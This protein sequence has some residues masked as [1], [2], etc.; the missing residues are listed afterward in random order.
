MGFKAFKDLPQPSKKRAKI[1]L[2][3]HRFGDLMSG[4][5]QQLVEQGGIFPS[6]KR[7]REVSLETASSIE[8]GEERTPFIRGPGGQDHFRTRMKRDF[9]VKFLL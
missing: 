8:A 3:A 4:I 9:G 7:I 5:R 2:S 6:L 1:S